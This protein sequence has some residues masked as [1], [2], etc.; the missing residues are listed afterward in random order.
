M[1]VDNVTALRVVTGAGEPVRCSPARRPDL[2]HAVLAGLGQCGIIVEATLRLV[3]APRTVRH[4]LLAYDDLGTYVEDQ[5]A[6]VEEDR[7]DYVGG[8]VFADARG[9][10]RTYMM[11]VVAYG[12]CGRS[13]AR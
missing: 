5:R 9:M 3:R 8:Q 12:P 6:L 11:E 7:F 2:F 1:Q 4:Y 10:F 13:R